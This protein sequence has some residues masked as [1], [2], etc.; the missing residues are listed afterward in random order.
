[1]YARLPG[2]SL[3]IQ[4]GGGGGLQSA[5]GVQFCCL[6]DKGRRAVNTEC[7]RTKNVTFSDCVFCQGAAQ[8]C[9]VYMR[10]GHRQGAVRRC[11]V[12]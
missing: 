9:T 2:I 12:F 5:E 3:A 11:F 4:R 8:V 10:T 1:M 6:T 7:E